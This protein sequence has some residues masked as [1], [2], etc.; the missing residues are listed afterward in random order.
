M[1]GI[2]SNLSSTPCSTIAVDPVSGEIYVTSVPDYVSN[3]TIHHLDSNGDEI[4]TYS[5]GVG[6]N[7]IILD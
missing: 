7:W 3:S 4:T 1:Q 5:V 6:A 2:V